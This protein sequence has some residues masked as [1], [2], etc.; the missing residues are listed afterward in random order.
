M[1]AAHPGAGPGPAQRPVAD[2]LLDVAPGQRG[3]DDARGGLR[4][5]ADQVH[6]AVR[7]RGEHDHRIVPQVDPVR[8]DADP[9]QRGPAQQPPGQRP[10]AG[11]GGD[12]RGGGHRQ[13]HQPALVDERRVLPG[14]PDHQ[15]D[16]DQPGD[17]GAVEHQ[18][19]RRGRAGSGR[20]WA[21]PW[22]APRRSAGRRAGVGALINP[23]RVQPGVVQ[24]QHREGRRRGQH[25]GG[26]RQPPH[27]TV[28]AG[29]TRRRPSSSSHGQTR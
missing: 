27:R 10:R 23:G 24:H 8:P 25:Q 28:A 20:G 2:G 19:S 22:R 9:A 13:Q 18:P 15:A 4:R 12:R 16:G 21:T 17:P 6:R 7:R 14:P 29:R 26:Q 5:G 3:Q 11:R 1:Q